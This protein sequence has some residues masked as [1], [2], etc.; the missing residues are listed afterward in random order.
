MYDL[1]RTNKY[2]SIIEFIFYPNSYEMDKKEMQ[3]HTENKVS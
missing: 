1:Q 3:N 2:D